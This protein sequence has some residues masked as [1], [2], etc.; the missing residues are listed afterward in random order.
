[1][2]AI[3]KAADDT[4]LLW[5]SVMPLFFLFL[6]QGFVYHS[7]RNGT[8]L[9]WNIFAIR[10]LHAIEEETFCKVQRF[11]SDWHANAFAGATVRK[12]TRGKW[13]FDLYEDILFINLYPAL[14]VLVFVI[15]T[16]AVQ[17]PLMGLVTA[18]SALLYMGINI[19]TVM[20]INA[21]LF[22]ASAARDTR[23]GASMADSITA[24]AVVKSFGAESREDRIF[25]RVMRSWRLRAFRSWQTAVLTDLL[26]RYLSELMGGAIIGT[27]IYLWAHG[28]ASAGDVVFAFTSYML[29]SMYLRAL[30]DQVSNLQKA[31]SDMED[32][33][34]FWL[35][36]DEMRDRPGA[37]ALVVT[38]GCIT[39]DDVRFI[40]KS[41]IDPLFDGLNVDIAPG[42][43]VALVG[44][45][46][47]GKTSFV[48]LLQRLYD[49]QGGE[50]RIDGQNIAGVTQESLRANIALVQQEPI[51]FHRSI[52]ANISYGRPGASMEEIMEAA[53][54]AYAH[55][56]IASLP[57]GYYTLV[58]ERGVKLSGG[59]RQRVAIARAVLAD[60]PILVLDEATSSLDSVS[61]HYIQKALENLVKGKTTITVAHR[62]ATIQDADRILVFDKGRIVAEGPHAELIKTSPIY[63]ELYEMQILDKVS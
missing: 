62:L 59:E 7:I 19:Y 34:S 48:K 37:K 26:R 41:K 63:R 28:Q 61:E 31:M 17:W 43:R 38:E 18:L 42:E 13:S 54:Q 35:R 12:I 8:L 53:K 5:A 47:S 9:V 4:S 45:S 52:A 24:N 39:F 6:A 32:V 36:E 46:G 16:M 22:K 58:G 1:M 3:T 49:V 40:Y 15:I 20:T 60:A 30:G 2:D 27:A 57:E 23:V 51:L 21:P 50:I 55:D 14:L 29:L 25:G 56:F 44:H 11:S 10:T 33:V